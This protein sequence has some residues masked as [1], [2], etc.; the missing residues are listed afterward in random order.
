MRS[1][2]LPPAIGIGTITGQYDH[3]VIVCDCCGNQLLNCTALQLTCYRYP[4]V[5]RVNT[6]AQPPRMAS[7]R[8]H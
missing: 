2:L 3:R 6:N 4:L 8:S 7:V 5:P 1:V